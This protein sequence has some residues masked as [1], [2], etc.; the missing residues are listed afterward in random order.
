M[1]ARFKP[2]L[3]LAGS[4]CV[5]LL[6]L[7]A[8]ACI[9]LL[10]GWYH[11]APEEG[12]ARYA[13]ARQEDVRIC[14]TQQEEGYL[15]AIWENAATGETSMT[16]LERQNALGRSYLR[17]MGAT[18]LSANGTVFKIYQTAEGDG[19]PQKSLVIVAC[20]NRSGT[21]DRCELTY[22]QRGAN[23]SPYDSTETVSVTGP[24]LLRA[25]WLPGMCIAPAW[26][27]TG[28]AP[29][30]PV[31]APGRS[32][33]ASAA[34]AGENFTKKDVAISVIAGL[35]PGYGVYYYALTI[36]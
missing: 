7:V 20:D 28:R 14:V 36:E 3:I 30:P 4:L 9:L 11:G 6:A 21:L 1:N 32:P 13:G 5:C 18:P 27:L 10:H 17:P 8:Y 24:F 26:P 34:E 15:Y 31:T 2:L 19:K 12:I 35:V 23:G 22:T 25:Q 33:P 16:F 29:W